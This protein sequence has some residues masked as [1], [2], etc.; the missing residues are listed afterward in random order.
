MNIITIICCGRNEYIA[1]EETQ[2]NENA[3]QETSSHCFYSMENQQV[4]KSYPT[5]HSKNLKV[6]FGFHI[7]H[8]VWIR[9]IHVEKL[10][11][12]LEGNRK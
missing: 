3:A 9:D 6:P 11:G 12:K 2:S 5:S 4:V 1:D 7:F 8:T 10:Y